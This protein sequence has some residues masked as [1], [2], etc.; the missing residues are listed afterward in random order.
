MS[1]DSIL[2]QKME[3]PSFDERG[4]LFQF[5]IKG[6]GG[7]SPRQKYYYSCNGTLI[8]YSLGGAGGTN[9]GSKLNDIK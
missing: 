3:M 6:T 5:E 8:C 2:V 7:Y 1:S 9:C 4:F